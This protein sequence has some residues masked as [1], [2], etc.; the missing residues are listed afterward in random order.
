VRAF[1]AL[2]MSAGVERALAEFI[3]RM[4]REG[5]DIRWTRTEKLHLTLRF[6]GAAV[7]SS[8]LPSF[9][10]ALGEI[11]AATAPFAIE[12]RGTGAFPNLNRPR[13]VW[14]GLESADLIALA[15]KIEAAA[16]RF[17]FAPERRPYSPHL[18]IGRVRGMRGWG[19][20]RDALGA[21][22]R[23]EFGKSVAD[24]IILYRSIPG[25]ESYQELARFRFEHPSPAGE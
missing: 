14:A 24:E 20:V 12:A 19:R 13:V 5:G 3:E 8:L 21:A 16:V 11:A 23:R 18:T 22:S 2:K 15:T 25:A 4:R 7:D 9:G 1:A 17:G 10:D 6:L